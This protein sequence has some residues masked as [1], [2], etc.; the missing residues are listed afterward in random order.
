M[1]PRLAF[2]NVLLKLEGGKGGSLEWRWKLP[3][4]DFLPCENTICVLKEFFA[5]IDPFLV[6]ADFQRLHVVQTQAAW[7]IICATPSDSGG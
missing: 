5:E 3:L 4:A 6:G 2:Q 7:L 1:S